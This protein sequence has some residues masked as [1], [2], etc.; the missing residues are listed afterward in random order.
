MSTEIEEFRKH[1]TEY[2][3]FVRYL[4]CS[5]EISVYLGVTKSYTLNFSS[6]DSNLVDRFLLKSLVRFQ[7]MG[8]IYKNVYIYFI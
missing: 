5:S 4:I 1:R 8:K 7:V 6:M 3:I 2:M